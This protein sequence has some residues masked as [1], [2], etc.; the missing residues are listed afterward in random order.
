M[1][2]VASGLLTNYSQITESMQPAGT[3]TA[4]VGTGSVVVFSSRNGPLF[5]YDS[6]IE[7]SDQQGRSGQDYR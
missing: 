1:R 7:M 4:F 3:T 2:Q 6:A 5:E